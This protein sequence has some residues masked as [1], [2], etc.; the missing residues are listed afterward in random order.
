MNIVKDYTGREYQFYG[1]IIGAYISRIRITG[2]HNNGET[3]SFTYDDNG[4]LIKLLKTR[5]GVS[6][7]DVI[8]YSY[9]NEQIKLD[10]KWKN[11]TIGLDSKG[12]MV[13]YSGDN[14]SRTFS[15]PSDGH[16]NIHE[17]IQ[18]DYLFDRTLLYTDGSL[19]SQ[20]ISYSYPGGSGA[21][22]ISYS[23]T[24]HTDNYSIDF[25]HSLIDD[26]KLHTLPPFI[27][28]PG[29]RNQYLLSRVGGDVS[30][31]IS[32]SFEGDNIPPIIIYY[33]YFF[34]NIKT[35]KKFILY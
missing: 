18:T 34:L 27:A 26:M 9:F 5:V 11:E 16:V 13:S 10:W 12:R 33:N 7:Y 30:I 3:Y 23:Y 1:G 2:E 24:G 19:N 21:D 22:N 32:S 8:T 35:L 28:F 29:I 17:K 4:R 6:G 20:N 14:N 15:Y 25:I 31:I